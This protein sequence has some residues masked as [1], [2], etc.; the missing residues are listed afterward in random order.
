M[1]SDT[2]ADSLHPSRMPADDIVISVK[3]L[4][5]TYRLFAHPGD[6]IKQAA[7]LGLRR[8]HKEFTALRDV[9]LEIRKGETIGIIG[10]NGSGKSTLLQLISGILKPTSG[11]VQVKGRISAL[12]EL[13]AGFNP[14]FTGRENVY[15]QGALMGFTRMQ[16]D[17]RFAD[18]A[19][20]ADI[21]EF[22]DQPVRTYSSGM[23]VR[24][25]FAVAVFIEPC[26]LIVDE[27]LAVGDAAFQRK[28]FAQIDRLQASG[29]SIVFVSHDMGAIIAHCHQALLLDRG[30]L[31]LAGPPKEVVTRYLAGDMGDAPHS[32]RKPTPAAA[33]PSFDP[34]LT[35][36]STIAYPTQ[37]A[38][39]IAPQI[40]TL[41]GEPAN[42]LRR[43]QEY[44]YSFHI[45][46]ARACASVRC[47][48]LIKTPDGRELGGLTAVVPDMAPDATGMRY[49][50]VF[51]F[52]CNLLPG[53]Y[54]LNAGVVGAD[55]TYLHRIIDAAMF[56][57]MPE[58]DG[59]GTGVIDFSPLH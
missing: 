15:F 52:R 21:G 25:A 59:C 32:P 46:F 19:A 33:S 30:R 29:C 53:T 39:I 9:S 48:M 51:R 6:R 58:P 14:E 2:A 13:G 38:E 56:T 3:N 50:Q 31:A 12:L 20:F 28:C 27:A 54:F 10:R 34:Q 45:R 16:M 35:P 42:L 47:G 18:I 57:V 22:I 49:R 43:G 36:L 4:T 8:Y 1:R 5:K 7:T 23:F 17:K 11:I 41:A 40:L 26:I 24:L 44:L 55:G 37:G